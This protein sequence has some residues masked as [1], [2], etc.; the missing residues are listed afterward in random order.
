MVWNGRKQ[1]A[2]EHDPL[3]PHAHEPNPEPPSLA[4]EFSLELPD[5]RSH[6]ITLDHLATLPQ[7]TVPNHAIVSTGH[8]TSGPFA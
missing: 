1:M 8:G 5:G 6:Q 3:R 7:T 2:H 4:P